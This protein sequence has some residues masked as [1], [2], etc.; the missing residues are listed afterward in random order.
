MSS[1]STGLRAGPAFDE[2]VVTIERDGETVF[3]SP[4]RSF[5]DVK[6]RF[7]LI[8]EEGDGRLM[9]TG[10]EMA[11]LAKPIGGETA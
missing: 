4:I 1:E 3:E 5:T 11:S 2:I 7:M 9:V 10:E 6:D 8:D